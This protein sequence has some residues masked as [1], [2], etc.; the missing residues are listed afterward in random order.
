MHLYN[1]TSS[2]VI[3]IVPFIL[4]RAGEVYAD[5]KPTFSDP[6]DTAKAANSCKNTLLH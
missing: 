3:S 4:G 6:T 1:L 5:E 2:V